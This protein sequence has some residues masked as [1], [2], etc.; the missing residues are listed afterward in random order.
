MFA[1]YVYK[2]STYYTI[3]AESKEFKVVIDSVVVCSDHVKV[4]TVMLTHTFINAKNTLCINLPVG[5]LKKILLYW[6]QFNP[7]HHLER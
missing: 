4:F 6:R 3:H 7:H 2:G 1:R 5:G